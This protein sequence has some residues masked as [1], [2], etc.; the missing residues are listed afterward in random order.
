MSGCGGAEAS[1]GGRLQG[2]QAAEQVVPSP[3]WAVGGHYEDAIGWVEVST[4]VITDLRS[5]PA[6]NIHCPLEPQQLTRSEAVQFSPKR[7]VVSARSESLQ[8]ITDDKFWHCGG[9]V[10]RNRPCFNNYLV[11]HRIDLQQRGF[12]DEMIAQQQRQL[13]DAL[14]SDTFQREYAKE[15]TDPTPYSQ[16]DD[17]QP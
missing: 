2:V 4:E 3:V 8:V 12:V 14:G 6:I 16:I 17:R 1:M 9:R 10:L 7:C 5:I 11:P 13:I 15:L